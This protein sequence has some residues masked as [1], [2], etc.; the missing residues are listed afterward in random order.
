M[1]FLIKISHVNN[2]K[3]ELFPL[4]LFHYLSYLKYVIKITHLKTNSL[5]NFQEIFPFQ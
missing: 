3:I 5:L 1:L 4:K 2:D